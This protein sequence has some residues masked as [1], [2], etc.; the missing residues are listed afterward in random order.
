MILFC[1]LLRKRILRVNQVHTYLSHY[2]QSVRIQSYSGPYSVG[3]RKN[4]DQNNSE[5]GQFL[6]SDPHDKPY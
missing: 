5:Y 4:A 1:V 6:P 2:V 3:I